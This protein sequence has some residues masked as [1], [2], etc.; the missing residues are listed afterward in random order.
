[1][2]YD[3]WKLRIEQYFQVQD[4]A[5]WD[6]IENG[7]SFKPVPRTTA[8]ADGTSTST[9][10]C[11][12][13]TKEK[14]QKKNDVKARS[15]LLMALPNEH[16]LTFSQYKD[17]KTFFEAIQA[18]F[19]G[20]DDT[21]KSQ[22][23]LLKQ[24]YEN[25]N[26]S[27]TESLD[28]I[29]NRL[30]AEW[31]TH[32]VVW[33]NKADLDTIS[34]DDLYN[35]FKIVEQQVKR[36]VV[37]SSSLGSPNMAFLSS[38]DTTN[39]V[40]TSNMQVSVVSTP[41][42]TVS[43]HDNTAN[44]SDAT[45]FKMAVSF[46][47]YESKKGALQ[48][49]LK[50]QGYFDSRCS[51]HMTKNISH[52]TNFIEHDGRY[53]AFEGGA[54]GGKITGKGIIGTGG[55]P[56]WLFDID[57]LLK[58]MNYAPV[59][60]STNSNDFIGKGASF[61]AGESSKSSQDYIL[62]PLWKDNSL[63]DSSS[64]DSDGFNKDN[65]G[66]SQVNES[67]IQERP[68]VKSSTKT[69]NTTGPVN[70]ATPTYAD[71]P[72]DPLMPDLE[73]AKIF[74]D[75]YD[76]RDEG[77]EAD[78]N[79]LEIVISFSPIPSTRI[80]KD[81]PKEH[82][83]KEMEPKKKL[84]DLPLRKRAIGTIWVYRN[85]RDQRG[86]IF[87]NKDRLVAQGHR[88]EEGIDYD[89]VFAPVA[90]IEAIKLFLTN[91]SFMDFTVYQMDVKKFPNRVYKV[92]KALYGLYQALRAWYVTLSTYLLDNGFIRGTIDKTLLI[93]KIKVDILLVQVEQRKDG[94]FLSQDKYV[95][96][97][98][99]KFG[100]S[101]VKSASTPIKTLKTLSKHAAGKDVDVHLYRSM[102]GLLMY[103]TSS[104]PDI[105]FVVCACLIFQVQPKVSHMHAVKRIFRYLKGQLTLGLWYPKDSPLELIAYSDSD[106]ASASLDR[107]STAGGCQF[108]C[109]RLISW[110]CKK[111][112]I[113]AN[114]ITKAEY[115]VASNFYG[116]VLWL[117]NQL[118]DY[119][120]NLMQTKC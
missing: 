94:I 84:V 22:R 75:A 85:K 3:M 89:E 39:E 119:G 30:H 116:Q 25:F 109:S 115:I 120:Y 19:G 18:R 20:N 77:A 8:N 48:D 7:N 24:M 86:I 51:R 49:A 12:L 81:H 113:V 6:V 108:L 112:T 54:K 72:N 99:K 114:S 103:L 27:S 96:D 97:I 102:I 62:M 11:P 74:D 34:F 64:Q 63:F 45:V 83:I 82:I 87:R 37:S 61:D 117:Q 16:L 98:L 42:S 52:L 23:A 79:N 93:K 71:Y 60:A 1:G 57:A 53:V 15:M 13:T 38:P 47:E 118:L 68:N 33:R 46:A 35:N 66:P 73:D 78:N 44:L 100:F 2:D 31:N 80:H 70:I 107:K 50:D 28:F 111:Q 9:I 10:P 59:S 105:M 101:S 29:F 92:E 88:Q 32:V 106:Y 4:Y 69:V 17:A 104:R 36:T 40:D 76:D 55:G 14:T 95:S 43:S 90:R 65:H 56:E 5:L 21:K 91:A 26:A 110:Q 67:D 41:V 58:L